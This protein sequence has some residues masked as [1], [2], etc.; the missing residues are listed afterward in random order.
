M[1]S[2][3]WTFVLGVALACGSQPRRAPDSGGGAGSGSSSSQQPVPQSEC[4]GLPPAPTSATS[5]TVGGSDEPS[6]GPAMGDGSGAVGLQ[7]TNP[8]HATFL[9]FM[10]GSTGS[11]KSWTFRH[12]P[13]GSSLAWVPQPDGFIAVYNSGPAAGSV[14]T[15]E[16][17]DRE[18]SYLRS[19]ASMWGSIA[20]KQVPSGGMLVAG[21]FGWTNEVAKKRQVWMFSPDLAVHWTNDLAA[22]GAIL[23]LGCDGSSH[24][25]ILTDGGSSGRITG[26][27]LEANGNAMT[28]E[29]IVLESFEAGPDTWLETAPLIEGGVA[30]RR[31]DQQND[32][33]GRPYRTAR[34]LA[35][36]GAG[37]SG[38]TDAPAWLKSR[39][40]TD[41]AI[42]RGN[43]AYAVLPMGA[44]GT[45][46]AQ[47]IEVLA[48]D[49]TSC[50]A[51]D[52]T[53]AAGQCRTEDVAISLD[54]TPIQPLPRAAGQDT[55]SYRWWTHALR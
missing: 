39:P 34:W 53:I 30:I 38:V 16:S 40:D 55:C 21:V 18:G 1:R 7:T 19:S 36:V 25:L 49:G 2:I 31:V 26:Q 24:C 22:Q 4:A 46:C 13:S 52:A 6:C 33:S 11:E 37:R 28:P 14:V 42:V 3:G 17:R 8:V 29:F 15:L 10:D 43:K 47:K 23:G 41:L 54:G 51:L 45:D 48:P 50:G 12:G 44:P 32:S 35:S 9:Y 27:W 5:A 20:T